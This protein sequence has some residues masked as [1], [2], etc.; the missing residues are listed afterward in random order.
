MPF[1]TPL[2]PS[3]SYSLAA[4]SLSIVDTGYFDSGSSKVT[5]IQFTPSGAQS[6]DFLLALIGNDGNHS[7]SNVPNGSTIVGS[8]LSNGAT[9]FRQHRMSLTG[10]EGTLTWTLSSQNQ[11]KAYFFVVRNTDATTP[12]S[13]NDGISEYSSSNGV[14]LPA[15]TVDRDGSAFIH[16]MIHDVDGSTP[17]ITRPSQTASTD[18]EVEDVGEAYSVGMHVALE[19]PSTGSTGTREWTISP[20]DSNQALGAVVQ[21]D[22]ATTPP[23]P[24]STL[25][26]DGLWSYVESGTAANNTSSGGEL[27]AT[28]N[29]VSSGP[30]A[31]TVSGQRPLYSSGRQNGK[32]GWV[33]GSG[34]DHVKFDTATV[35]NNFDV[36]GSYSAIVFKTNGLGS[37][38][39]PRLWAQSDSFYL[40]L[41]AGGSGSGHKLGFYR[42]FSVSDAWFVS[43]NDVITDGQAHIVEVVFDTASPVAP[44]TIRVDGTTV[45][46]TLNSAGVGTPVSTAGKS[47]YLGN[48]EENEGSTSSLD[49]GFSGD[50][51]SFVATDVIPPVD[52]QKTVLDELAGSWNILVGNPFLPSIEAQSFS[53]QTGSTSGTVVGTAMATNAGSSPTWT[54]TGSATSY[55]QIDSSTGIV[56][57]KPGVTLP[58]VGTNTTGTL[59]VDNGVGTDSGSV[60]ISVVEASTLK[61]ARPSWVANARVVS[62]S[63]KPT[64]VID[65]T[66]N[67]NGEDV[68]ITA[69][70]NSAVLTYRVHVKSSGN[71]KFRN[72]A[73][74]GGHYIGTA[75]ADKGGSGGADSVFRIQDITGDCWF[76]G[77]LIEPG[78][79]QDF[80]Q[81]DNDS[82]SNRG[83]WYFQRCWAKN[84]TGEK[85]ARHGD[86][87]QPLGPTGHIYADLWRFNTSY[88]GFFVD[89]NNPSGA[90]VKGF[91]C[92]NGDAFHTDQT[93]PESHYLWWT[94][95]H[96]DS[97]DQFT[98]QGYIGSTS[99]P[100][101]DAVWSNRDTGRAPPNSLFW[102]EQWASWNGSNL[103]T[104]SGANIDGYI[105]VGDRPGGALLQDGPT[106]G[107]FVQNGSSDV[108]GGRGY[109]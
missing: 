62:V 65:V 10:S 105:N 40:H 93:P 7:L 36:M 39:Y 2:P 23:D 1:I 47:V 15:L 59:E 60:T 24:Q 45:L 104:I 30:D 52:H 29:Q 43:T 54:L 46:L 107:T 28:N 83:S 4:A 38:S 14:T 81:F 58:A 103:L 63:S 61:Y 11:A 26:V 79:H 101:V 22:T 71:N 69:P 20:N 92:T 87:I 35:Q 33:F 106:S 90:R 34:T 18:M 89:P 13:D 21:P 3:G 84:I 25:E 72:V 49:R 76:E 74:I 75:D 44:P 77:L 37:S 41:Q 9:T 48:R 85:N 99:S 56:S 16:A 53:V 32:H 96:D 57:V 50:I 98:E 66:P 12:I 82:L 31:T 94:G 108:I 95:S 5:D 73:V 70:A 19:H 17:T 78:R 64:D 51:Y 86:F 109:T 67:S 8:E 88:Q 55:Y 42:R 80:C 6:G 100:S 27:T 102:P 97:N 91:T 68:L